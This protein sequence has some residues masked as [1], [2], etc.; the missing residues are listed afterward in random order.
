MI[1]TTL[2]DNSRIEGR[3]DLCVERGLSLHIETSGMNILFD[4]G[5]GQT[6]C[7]NAPRLNVDI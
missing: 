7:D 2:V 6:F 4:M 1:V 3:D 5:S